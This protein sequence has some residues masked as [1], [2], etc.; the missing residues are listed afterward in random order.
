LWYKTQFLFLV[1]ENKKSLTAKNDPHSRQQGYLL[2]TLYFASS[3]C[4]E[5]AFIVSLFSNS[6]FPGSPWRSLR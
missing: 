6:Y 2:K 5:F 1:V 3:N 4:L